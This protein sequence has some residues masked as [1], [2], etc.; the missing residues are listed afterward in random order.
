MRLG[1]PSTAVVADRFGVW[2][3]AVAAIALSVLHDVGLIT[4]NY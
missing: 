1:L 4:S 3:R 2:D